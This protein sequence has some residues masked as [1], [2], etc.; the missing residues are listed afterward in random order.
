MRAVNLLPG[1]TSTKVG[2]DRALA[3]GIALTV[4]VAAIL[5]GGFFLERANAA[6]ARQRLADAQAALA[7]ALT[8]QPTT[9]SSGPAK[10]SVPVVLSQQEPW[11]VALDAALSTRV[12]WDTLL[13]QLEYAVPDRVTLTSVTLGGASATAGSAA[14]GAIALGGSAFSSDD[15]A[16]FL[17]MLARL[18]K[19][20]QV[21]L[22][23][24]ATNAGSTTHTFS[25]TAQLRLPAALTTPPATDTTATTT[26]GASA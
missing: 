26:T 14:S 10:L 20:S 21:T 12:A 11:H 18:P 22:V 16:V 8:Q 23:S 15:V 13:R 24:D 3:V 4:L 7:Q 9:H 1:Q 5:A 17:S 25:I 2:V 19:V 6:S